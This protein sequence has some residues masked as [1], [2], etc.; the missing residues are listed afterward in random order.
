MKAN[1]CIRVDPDI[2]RRAENVFS[3]FGMNISCAIDI[4][5]RQAIMCQGFPFDLH[6]EDKPELQPVVPESEGKVAF[7]PQMERT[8]SAREIE[9]AM[10]LLK[11]LKAS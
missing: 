4:F 11:V 7:L 9:A 3:H 5:L 10:Q 2:R 6:V 8:Y 1:L